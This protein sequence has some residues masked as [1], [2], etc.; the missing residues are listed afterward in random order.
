MLHNLNNMYD[1]ELYTLIF[2]TEKNLGHFAKG[3]N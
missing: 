2:D 3:I 1:E